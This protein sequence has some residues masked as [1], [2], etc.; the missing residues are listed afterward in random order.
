MIK[1]TNGKSMPALE[2]FGMALE[3]LKGHLIETVNKSLEG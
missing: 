1:A 3:Y 2:I